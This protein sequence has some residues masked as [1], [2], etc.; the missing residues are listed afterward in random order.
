M[1]KVRLGVT[2]RKA[3][4]RGAQ[5]AAVAA[6]A[7]QTVPVPDTVGIDQKATVVFIVGLIGAI[8]KGIHNYQKTSRRAPFLGSR[9]GLM[10]SLA[11]LAGLMAGCV[12][13]TDAAGNTVVSVDSGTL[14]TAWSIYEATLN[15][16]QA[17]QAERD[18]ASAADRARIEA[19]LRALEPELQAAWLRAMGL[20]DK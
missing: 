20:A 13:T 12:T 1:A 15:R 17:L 5:Y 6:A 19:E 18:A 4:W 3:F 9:S 14:T 16:K 2:A 11:G 10:L 7:I 8:A